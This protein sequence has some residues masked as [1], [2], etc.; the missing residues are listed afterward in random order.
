M[1]KAPTKSAMPA[2]AEQEVA[3]EGDEL[4][5]ALAVRCCLFVAGADLGG[6]GQGARERADQPLLRHAVLRCDGDGVEAG[7]AKDG[8]RSLDVE[9]RD[10]RAAE[11]VDVAE[12]RDAGELVALDR[13]FARDLDRVAELEALLLGGVQVDDDLAR[14]RGPVAFDELERVEALVGG[15]DAEPEGRVVALDRLAV[16]VEDLCL[17]RVARQVEDRA[18]GGLDLR[19]RPHVGEHVLGDL[20][21]AGLRP[22]DELLARDDRVGLLVRAGEDRVERL[23]DRVGEDERAAD[24]RDAQDD[25]DR[26]QRRAELARQQA[27]EGDAPHRSAT[28][29]RT[30]RISD[31]DERPSSLTMTPSARKSTRSA[32]VA[33]RGSCVTITV[34]CP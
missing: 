1:T 31:C 13:P 23:L 17:V 21:L 22:L 18:G 27:A 5:H 14:P 19:Q 16:A 25:R 29:L 12:A 15:L 33:A 11:A 34:V 10:R 7:L 24:H 30:S 20:R 32:I 6:I 28:A 8:P 3:D 4:A 2:E 26:R 9:Q